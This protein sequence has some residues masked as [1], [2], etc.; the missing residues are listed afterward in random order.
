MKKLSPGLFSRSY[1]SVIVS[2]ILIGL[3]SFGVSVSSHTGSDTS[4]SSPTQGVAQQAKQPGMLGGFLN[5]LMPVVSLSAS[6]ADSF[7][8][9]GPGGFDV[10]A[11]G[12][13]DLNDKI[14]YITT[15][16]NSGGTDATNVHFTDTPG[17]NTTLVPGTVIVSPLA[18]ADGTYQTVGNMTLTSANINATCGGNPL[19]SVLCNDTL[20]GASLTG[21]GATQAAAAGTVVNNSNLVTTSNG[22]TVLLNTDGTFV[23]NPAAG[24]EGTD[25]F[26][27]TLTNS[28][29]TPAFT[30]NA[31]VTINVGGANG[32]VW[33][34][35]SGGAGTGTQI[36][37]ES[38]ATFN[39][40]N[41]GTGTGDTKPDAGNTIFL[42]EGAH[43]GPVTLLNNQKVIGQ[44]TT[45][46]LSALSAPAPQAGNAY[47]VVGNP[48]GTAV[49]I[50]SA[51]T[52]IT[53][54]SGNTLAGFT[55]GNS[56]KALSGSAVGNLSVREVVI[57]TNAQA[58]DITTSGTAISDATYTGF[59]S[60]TSAGGTNSISLIGMGG[61]LNLGSGALSGSTGTAFVIGSGTPSTGGNGSVNYSGTIATTSG[62]RVISIR[63]KTGGTVAFTGAIT[64]TLSGNGILLD[65]NTGATIRFSGGLNLS[66]SGGNTAFQATGGGT[67]E[68][69]DKNPCGSGSAVVNTIATTTSI[70]LNV[71]NTNIGS[72]GLIF[73]SI[74]VTGNGANPANGIIL[75]TTGSSAGL[76]VTA[77]GGACTIA[78]QTCTGGTIQGTSGDGMQLLSTKDV[79]LTL[80][81]VMNTGRQGIWG[82]NVNGFTLKNSLNIGAGDGDEEN[83]IL[84]EADA[85]TTAALATGTT[86]SGNYLIQDTVIDSPLQWGIRIHQNAGAGNV[87]LRRVTVQNN[88]NVGGLNLGEDAISIKTDGTATT[89][90]LVDDCDLLM[91]DA[92]V[93]GQAQGST[94]A[95][96]NLTVQNTTVNQ[97][98]ALP[99][100]IN[101]TTTS[102]ATGRLQ[103]TGNTLIGCS[104][105]AGVPTTLCS[106]GIDL[107]A[108]INSTLDVIIQNNTI[109]DA[110]IGTGIE[111]KVN[112]N[113]TGR[114]TISGNNI[115]VNP[116]RI[117]MDF[118]A[119][120]V[121][122]GSNQ[123]GA[124]HVTLAN[125]TISGIT[126][127]FLPGFTFASGASGIANANTMCVNLDTPGAGSNTVNGTSA[128][129]VYAYTFRQ[130]QGTTFQIQ[131]LTGSGADKNNVETFIDSNHA[132]GT[133]AKSAG[134]DSGITS[135]TDVFSPGGAAPG[136]TI[137]NYTNGT[138]ATP[139][140]PSQPPFVSMLQGSGNGE[141]LAQNNSLQNSNNPLPAFFNNST[142]L[143]GAAEAMARIAASSSA[144]TSLSEI[145][146]DATFELA[147]ANSP[148]MGSRV[149]SFISSL[150]AVVMPTA[151]AAPL[152]AAPLPVSPVDVGP[153]TLPAGKTIKVAFDVTVDATAGQYSN[154]GTVTADGPISILT[155]DPAAGGSADPTI[156]PGDA[157]DLQLTKSDAP[158]PV[159][160]GNNITYTINF[161]N[162][163][164][165]AANS[166]A[167]SDAVPANTTFVSVTTPAGW[168]R[169]D[170]VAVGGTG[171]LTFTKNADAADQETASFTIVVKV[172]SGVA[173]GTTITN[174][175]T[176][177]SPKADSDTNNNTATATT[178]TQTR[179][180][181]A[182]TNADA[183]DPV[184]VG[185]NITYTINFINN[186]PSDAQSVTLTNAVPANTTLV[187]A[188]TVSPGWSRTDLIPVGGTG[189]VVFSNATVVAGGTASFTIVV[190]VNSGTAGG[191]VITDNAVAAST[192]TDPTP[193]NNTGTATTTANTQADLQVTKTGSPDP[194]VFTG[195][196]ITYTI[197]FKNNGP[198]T[199]QSVQLTDAVPTNTTFV[200][201]TVPSGWSRTDLVAVGGTGTLTFTKPSAADQETATFT[202]VVKVDS[203]A[204]GG[205]TITN[206]AVAASTTTDQTPGNNTGTATTSVLAC[207][208]SPTVTSI[209]DSGAN[210]LREA[211][212]NVCPGG[213]ITITATGTIQLLTALPDIDKNMTITGPGANQLTVQGSASGPGFRV[214]NVK[215]TATTVNISKL[216][217]GNSASLAFGGGLNIESGAS[218]QLS[219]SAVSYNQVAVGGGGGIFNAGT[220][221]ILRSTVS[222]NVALLGGGGGILNTGTLNVYNSTVSTNTVN[223]GTGGGV[224]NSGAGVATF[225]NSTV[226]SNISD[227]AGGGISTTSSGATNIG[228]TIVAYSVSTSN[229]AVADLSPGTFTS[230]GHNWVQNSGTATGLV[231]TDNPGDPQIQPALANNGGPTLTQ[232]PLKGSPV[233]EAG[234]NALIDSISEITDQRDTGFPRKADSADANTTQTVDIGAVEF[235]PD[236]EDISNQTTAEDTAKAVT[237][238]V[239][240]DAISITV[241]AASSNPALVTSDV[242]HLALT[243]SGGSRTLTITPN[244]DANSPTD[245]G[246]TTITVTVTASNGQVATD[247]FDLTVTEVNDAPTAVD[248]TVSDIAEDSGVYSIPIATLLANDSA[249]PNETAQSLSL[250]GVSNPTGGTVQVNGA[251]VEFTPTA[252]Y[253]G[254]AGFDY[255]IQDNG[256]TAGSDDFK[257]A[258]AHVSFNVTAVNDNPTVTTTAGATA[259]VEGNNVTSTPVEVD[260]GV[261]VDDVDTTTLASATVSITGNFQ[262]GEDVLAFVNNSAPSFG[263]IQVDSYVGGVLSLS[264]PGATA[265]LTQWQN[266]LR[267]VTYTNLSDTPDTSTRTVSFQ[268]NDGQASNNLSTSA[269]KDVTVAAT[270]D[271]PTLTNNGLTVNED[272]TATINSGELSAGDLDN[273]AAQLIF[274]VGTAPTHGTL[275]N[276]GVQVNGGGTF[277]QDDIDN[278]RITYTHDGTETPAADSFTFTVTDGTD[279]LSSATFNITITPQDDAPVLANNNALTVVPG[280]TGTINNSK[281]SYTDADTATSALVY[282]V[283]AIPAHG[284]LKSTGTPLNNGDTFTQDD[285]NSGNIT[286]THNGGVDATDSFNFDI[287]DGTTSASSTFNININ[288]VATSVVTTTVDSVAGSLREAIATACPGNTITFNLDSS[289]DPGYDAGTQTFTIKLTAGELAINKNLTINGPTTARVVISGN[290]T[291]PIPANRS[292]VFNISSGTVNISNLTI[293]DGEAP[294]GG[295]IYNLGDLTIRNSTFTGNKAVTPSAEGGAIDSEGGTLTIY[296]STISGNTSD[297]AGGGVLNCGT[298]TA[299]LVN[300]TITGN[301]SDNDDDTF[302]EGGGLAQV[303]TPPTKVTLNNTIV[304]GN[305]RG[306]TGTTPD[307][308]FVLPLGGGSILDTASS[309]N[310]IGDAGTAGGLQDKST[311]AAHGNLVGNAGTGTIDI[312]TVLDTA[313]A[314]N[315]GV[316]KTH[317]LLAG[318]PAI[319]TGKDSEATGASLTTDQR[320]TGFARIVNGVDIGAFEV[321][322]GVANRLA[323]SVQPSNALAGASISPA[324]K[325]QIVDVGNNLVSSTANVT[326]AIGTNPGGGT[327]SGTTTV[328]AVGGTATFSN[329]SINNV[330]AGY[331]LAA[332]SSG[333]AGATSNAFNITSPA[334]LSGTKTVSGTFNPGGTV[335][336]TVVLSNA[337]PGAQ[338]DNPGN[339]FTDVLPAGLT[340][341]SA[342]ATGGVAVA[343]IPTNTVSWNGSI[344]AGGSV[345]ITINATVNGGTTIINQGAIAYDA[346]GN[347]TNE[348]AAV[349]DDPSVVGINNPTSFAVNKAPIISPVNVTRTSGDASLNFTIAALDDAEDAENT[350]GFKVNNTT[351]TGATTVTVNGVTISNVSI[352]AVGVV[353][354]DIVAACGATTANFTLQVTDSGGLSNTTNLTVTVN[355]NTAP[356]LTYGTPQNVGLGGSLSV[357]PATGPS[358]TG[359]ISSIAVQSQGTYT[360]TISVN[361]STGVVS[362]SNAAPA[363]THAITIRVTDNCGTTKDASFNLVVA[364]A[365]TTTTLASSANPSESGQDVTFTATVASGAGTPT[366][367]VTFKDN[368]VAISGCSNRPL[369]SGQAT[370][371]ATGLSVGNHPITADYSG[372]TNFTASTGTLS[373]GQVVNVTASISID[374]ISVTEGNSGTK[375]FVFTVTLSKASNLVVKVDF[376]TASGT[377]T[378]ATDYQSATGTLTF[379][380]GDPLT[381]SVTVQV[382]G[383]TVNE[384]NE[385]FFVNLTNPQNSTI[386][387]NQGQGTI[388]NDDAPGVQFS[389]NAYSFSEG[390]GHGDIT[391]TRTGDTSTPLTVDYITSDQSGTTPCQTN[392]TGFASDRCDYATAAGTLRF[393]AGQS[394]LT[395]PLV[396]IND[397][398]VE[399]SEQ[400]SIKLSNAQGGALGSVDTATVTITDNDTQVATANPIDDLDFF[401]R[402]LYIDFLGREPDPAGFNFWKARLTGT[403][404]AGQTCDRIDTA[405]RFF[406]SDEF[407]ERGYFVYLFYHAAL[408]RRPTYS[409]WIMDVSKLNGFKTV[410]EQEAA[411]DAF[412]QEFTSRQ[413]FMNLYN[414]AQTGQTFVD[415]LI[416]K[417]GVTPASKQTL[418]NNY[419]TVGREKTLRAFME[420]PE[421]QAAFVD[422]AFVSMLYFGLLRRNAETA[423]FNFWMQKL[424]DTNHDYRFLM[425]GF[426]NSDEYRYRY[427]Q[428]S[429]SSAESEDQ[430]TPSP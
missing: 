9:T 65:I 397:A 36:N 175:A 318:S 84:F 109:S 131:G 138:C 67:V 51:S 211:I 406:G 48:T 85:S 404:P 366:G 191:T 262:S 218:L 409:E 342:N 345:T 214:F 328:A 296:N 227:A 300:V 161:K 179:A 407:R 402:Q 259:F 123:T 186:G 171:T 169:T 44:D 154:Q 258:S 19:R 13:A 182:V 117:G 59:T 301:R 140:A 288:C 382:N 181:L 315:G 383:D 226:A 125:N 394:S 325:V 115:T 237:F 166:V 405:L 49:S 23:Y 176:V 396:L 187:S 270:N 86:L 118:Q 208:L 209:A 162:N 122:P 347:G 419:N 147:H 172:G 408:G 68:V 323:F 95:I 231:G 134:G 87:T 230:Q 213:T 193:G 285:I 276:N 400:L 308:L 20:F 343:T 158:D 194:T 79:S 250:T 206:N 389:S 327:L 291:D 165:S 188:A 159:S 381:Q 337:G 129:D 356:T 120:T 363:G 306:S 282:T 212:T 241:T 113:S 395:I 371:V 71:A 268:V 157:A 348:A 139:T 192:T 284:Q 1:R 224:L 150:A 41:T 196:N 249:G 45:A 106:I 350:L 294:F 46:T 386:S 116:N 137:I 60:V 297:G 163:G 378:A 375:N 135:W 80:T 12:K 6:M 324:V 423:G 365:T 215:S 340:L 61:T 26:W 200:S 112:E 7:P 101:F 40:N 92:G 74:N 398:Y 76:T 425:G 260:S 380:P 289:T 39:T 47:P 199:A 357:N 280:D 413:E 130:R 24:F 173:A 430:R 373:G 99:F 351:V 266:A 126:G 100:G 298:S 96:L 31:Q 236:V 377:A 22:G 257:G 360:G 239:G 8:T 261:T 15:I 174:T 353:A 105:G 309:N 271:T 149:G 17:A 336:Y 326:L 155:D 54:A 415:A 339:E 4:Q 21:F 333:L 370:C 70:G 313:L 277:T 369:S 287:S 156:T 203:G 372:D 379:N 295:G 195:Q 403:C 391:V 43:T 136:A 29:I 234:D 275:F 56:T 210:T 198:N 220:L 183:P 281:L 164:P 427:A 352:S 332:S 177:S 37:P 243:G 143:S 401:I 299:V 121:S 132:G 91:V 307:D 18:I 201:A 144:A 374:D 5:L 222:N 111:F 53:L 302:G 153:F 2:L 10:D 248:N 124:L 83:G 148:T 362:I 25:S 368:G 204:P 292:R 133:L 128:T 52:G 256:T 90:A 359:S 388:L 317:L 393:T 269:T 114:A 246:T 322:A 223:A 110:G 33:F 251:N 320:G 428:L 429:L 64:G 50:T 265:N 160:S 235:Y 73:R 207:T 416:Q 57:N 102:T 330:G 221:T 321:Q 62:P 387:D 286:Y 232:S 349:T 244:T 392:N 341:V 311:D 38:L 279:T 338:L 304:A 399:P 104:G 278:N 66:T 127:M 367:T 293:A 305:Y 103:A 376:A 189:N 108:S 107:D 245:G 316:T 247:T 217:I 240:D 355:A 253:S 225:I 11:D 180:D 420:T 410:A 190:Q 314:F 93:N 274:T 178:T 228:N 233:I 319:N 335:A 273:S 283:T 344:A 82:R 119:R 205:S 219:E 310:L 98:Q 94:G 358:D 89:N 14:R 88:I 334:A 142:D 312:S 141:Y 390:A 412:I 361:N 185:S 63:N 3:I 354:A 42:F 28:T 30:D 267:A 197:N 242:T 167:L 421:V 238:N 152:A 252:D 202:V 16:T 34:V 422:R 55:L 290:N 329:L 58:I 69:C 35:T 426:L 263:N 32:I 254:P 151:H 272:A 184:L 72:N 216:T 418:I 417:S 346:D 78:T 385:T 411:K 97:S 255:A 146:K 414:G 303:S 384:P 27:Y 81:R 75:D 424:I 331:T 264:S 364:Q 145:S 229:A 168:T 170:S 77:N